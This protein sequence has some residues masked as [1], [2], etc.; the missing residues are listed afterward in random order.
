MTALETGEEE[1]NKGHK[2]KSQRKDGESP[3]FHFL[4]SLV[5]NKH[6]DHSEV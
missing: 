2:M 3:S 4:R 6:N 1:E 5:R